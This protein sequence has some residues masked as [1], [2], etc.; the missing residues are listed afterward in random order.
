MKPLTPKKKVLLGFLLLPVVLM[1]V[2]ELGMVRLVRATTDYRQEGSFCTEKTDG[3]RFEDTESSW[4]SDQ[5][6]TRS[7]WRI[8]PFPLRLARTVSPTITR[9][10]AGI[11]RSETI[12][13][14]E[15]VLSLDRIDIAIEGNHW[16]LLHK[17]AEGT[18]SVDYRGQLS[19]GMPFWGTVHG[20]IVYTEAGISSMSGLREKI[21]RM[22]LEN[23]KERLVRQMESKMKA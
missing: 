23:V 16:W 15:G 1:I 10:N 4:R 7:E 12:Q 13:L 9:T 21:Y 22:V 2:A 8:G 11:F 6:T 14:R 17:Q 19:N 18:F 20:D 5:S 3:R